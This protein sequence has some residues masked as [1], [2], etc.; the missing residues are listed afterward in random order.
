VTNARAPFYLL[1]SVH[2]LRGSD[3]PLGPVIDNAI[4]E[5]QQFFFE[6]DLTKDG[7]FSEKMRAAAKYPDGVQIKGKIRPETYK[8]LQKITLSGVNTWQHLKPWAIVFMLLQHPG[9][10]R[11]SSGYGIERYVFDKAKLRSRPVA[12][13]ESVDE[14]V[15]VLSDMEDIESEV[16]L[17]QALVYA[18]E[19]PKVFAET[20]TAWK[21]GD[22]QRLYA[23]E[24][25]R[26]KEAPTVW[27]R[28]L[29]RRNVRWVPKIESAIKSGKPTMVVAGAMHF[30]GP[31]SVIA[32][33]KARGYKIEQL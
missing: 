19:D 21:G 4:K 27:W 30:S 9:Y 13:L 5:S 18:D 6:Y 2:K 29:D 1:G 8:Y 15:H 22:T 26:I 20:V 33:L 25:P 28:L 31:H 3:Y 10:E 12:G 16:F 32:M 24:A 17:L 11:V 7:A 23:L 14:H